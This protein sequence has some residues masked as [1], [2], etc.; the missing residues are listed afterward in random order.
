MPYKTKSDLPES[1]KHVLP[2]HAQ[3]IY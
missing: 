3:D 2:S 1:V